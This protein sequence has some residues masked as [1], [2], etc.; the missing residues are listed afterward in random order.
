MAYIV[1]MWIC[2]ATK[3][4]NIWQ[5]E[6]SRTKDIAHFYKRS[7]NKIISHKKEHKNK[8]KNTGKHAQTHALPNTGAQ[9]TKYHF[10]I[11]IYIFWLNIRNSIKRLL[12][13]TT[14]P[15]CWISNSHILPRGEALSLHCGSVLLSVAWKIDLFL[16]YR[17][18]GT[19]RRSETHQHSDKECDAP[20]NTIQYIK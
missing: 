10:H 7:T 3:C 17:P 6:E 18:C 1:T 11:H 20:L 9:K 19:I 8:N 14:S 15:E 4:Y 12:F 5:N 2:T 16:C 13:I